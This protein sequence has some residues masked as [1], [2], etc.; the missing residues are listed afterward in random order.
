M[1]L[2]VFR[3]SALSWLWLN[4]LMLPPRQLS[5]GSEPARYIELFLR[6][7]LTDTLAG[8]VTRVVG[9]WVGRWVGR[10]VGRSVGRWVGRSVGRSL[11]RVGPSLEYG[12]GS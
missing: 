1:H 6:L 10:S 8:G 4:W 3:I 9:R 2:P 11:G 12:S 7:V 5:R